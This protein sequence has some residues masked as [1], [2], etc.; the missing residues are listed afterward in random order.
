MRTSRALSRHLDDGLRLGTLV[1]RRREELGRSRAELA[2]RA[3][4]ST[5]TLT[6]I[7]RGDT[8]DPGLF[9]VRALADS[10]DW[11]LDQLLD[12]VDQTPRPITPVRFSAAHGLLSIGYEG[13]TADELVH[14]LTV[15]K[16]RILADVRLN[17]ISRKAGLSKRA[18][19]TELGAQSVE[20]MHLP[21]LGNPK[22][23]RAGF[24]DP[25]AT[26]PRTRYAQILH[27]P[28][29]ASATQHLARLAE[30]SL[31]A[32]LCFE[33]EELVC[34]RQMILDTVRDRSPHIVIQRA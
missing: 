17:P 16:V 24:A 25:C 7:E 2:R 15:R 3:Q 22:D 4:L 31:V 29:G 20:Y 5:E 33:R 10:L 6:K 34:H 27:S 19:A 14:E 30:R 26:Q 28:A 9:T 1:R 18:L 8:V 13:R 32:V 12:S 11:S 23:N 21:A